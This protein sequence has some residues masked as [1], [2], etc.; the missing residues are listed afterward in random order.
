MKLPTISIVTP[1]FNQGRFVA[2]TV[3]SV[4][5][6]R[7][8]KLEYIF[9]DGGSTDETLKQITPYQKQFFHFESQPDEG[10]SAAIAKGFEYA[11]GE[12]MAYLNSD[13]VLLPGTL[14]FV[15]DYFLAHPEIDFIY[16]HRCIIDETNQVIGH[17]IL[18]SHSN[19]LMSRWDLIPQ[20]SC[21]WR[22]SLFE[23]QG[24]IDPSYHFAMD[25]ELFVR[26]MMKG[27]FKR[28]NRFL[29]AFRMHKQ[30]KTATQLD[31]IGKEE[32]AR[33]HKMHQIYFPPIITPIAS[34]FFP[35]WVQLRS[36]VFLRLKES[37]PGLP[38]GSEFDITILWGKENNDR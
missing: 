26:Y 32:V 31:T 35:L 7:Y 13:D 16:G 25:Y 15:A 33:V 19:W 12:I 34:R 37:F 38:P 27:K 5:N 2:D 10:Q 14:S 6:Q 22:R 4:I 20:E 11:T 36:A 30:S 17:W 18:P 28:V 9:M 3:T 29:A 23:K 24:N 21:F 1:S 8:P